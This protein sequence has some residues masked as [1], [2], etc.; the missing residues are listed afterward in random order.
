ERELARSVRPGVQGHVHVRAS[1]RNIFVDRLTNARLQLGQIARQVHDD[2]ALLAIHGVELDTNLRAGVI[3]LAASVTGHR[4]HFK[5][6]KRFAAR[7]T[8]L[9][10]RYSCVSDT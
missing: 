5:I 6:P 8:S 10:P 4:S 7:S 1:A 3:G 9:S 2:V